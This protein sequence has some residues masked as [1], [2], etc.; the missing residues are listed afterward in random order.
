M[1]LQQCGHLVKPSG[2]LALGRQWHGI[3]AWLAGPP[4]PTAC[5]CDE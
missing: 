4:A 5:E 2:L 1:N 3:L